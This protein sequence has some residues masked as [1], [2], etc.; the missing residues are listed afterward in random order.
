MAELPLFFRGKSVDYSGLTATESKVRTGKKFIGA[1]SDDMRTGN[2]PEYAPVNYTL[3]VNGTYNIPVGIHNGTDTI[4][5]S[6]ATMPGQTVN[7]GVGEIIIECAGKYM[8]GDIVIM[9]VDNLYSENI[10]MGAKVGDPPGEV[11]GAFEGFVD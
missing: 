8:T 5:Q 11:T 4:S 6:I 2:V 3:P 1:G 10:K 9:P 7:P